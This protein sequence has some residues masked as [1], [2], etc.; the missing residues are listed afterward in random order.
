M[1]LW[2]GLWWLGITLIITE[3]VFV[4]YPFRFL[5]NPKYRTYWV[6]SFWALGT[7][8]MFSHS[9]WKLATKFLF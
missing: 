9:L 4:L 7:I 2:T 8:L 1:S 3:L 5:D 6:L